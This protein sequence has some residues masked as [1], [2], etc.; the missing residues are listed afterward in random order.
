MPDSPEEPVR[1]ITRPPAR[2]RN[3]E[4]M[5]VVEQLVDLDIHDTDI[6]DM[7]LPV[8]RVD[9]PPHRQV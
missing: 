8:D 7:K 1:D 4:N 2:H 3:D 9:V 6:L 5:P